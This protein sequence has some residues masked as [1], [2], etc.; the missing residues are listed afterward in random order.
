MIGLMIHW[1]RARKQRF[2]VLECFLVLTVYTRLRVLITG[3]IVKI[4]IIP[5]I[6]VLSSSFQNAEGLDGDEYDELV[7]VREMAICCQKGS[8]LPCNF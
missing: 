4:A 6:A 5:P 7:E 2:F 3:I 1:C 8:I